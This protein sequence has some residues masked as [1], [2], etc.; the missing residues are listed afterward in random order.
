[1]ILGEWREDK[2]S[3][4]ERYRME[5]ERKEKR[6]VLIAIILFFVAAGIA[7]KYHGNGKG[8]EYTGNDCDYVS[9]KW[10]C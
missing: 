10:A 4:M 2:L 9:S 5:K 1:M 7:L 8:P 3:Y 6:I